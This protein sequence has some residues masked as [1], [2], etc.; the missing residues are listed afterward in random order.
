MKIDAEKQ[1]VF[2]RTMSIAE[3][4]AR[5]MQSISTSTEGLRKLSNTNYA[6]HAFLDKGLFMDIA[7]ET[8]NLGKMIAR[9]V[10]K[11]QEIRFGKA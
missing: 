1:E 4:F 5:S 6:G 11:A 9:L 2:D 3:E 7:E 10:L 8:L